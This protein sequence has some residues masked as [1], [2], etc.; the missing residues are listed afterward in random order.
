MAMTH[1]VKFE[2][3]GHTFK[4]DC[5]YTNAGLVVWKETGT[6]LMPEKTKEVVRKILD[7]LGPI[8]QDYTG[9]TLF[10]VSPI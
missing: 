6:D 1:K 10:K 4:A 5:E 3:D 2:V 7:L 9:F 8:P